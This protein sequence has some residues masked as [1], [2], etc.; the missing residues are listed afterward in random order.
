M[1]W[2]ADLSP[3]NGGSKKGGPLYGQFSPRG[4]NVDRIKL[5]TFRGFHW[6]S[7]LSDSITEWGRAH[8]VAPPIR[9]PAACQLGCQHRSVIFTMRPSATKTE[10]SSRSRQA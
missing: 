7:G 1:W 10:T 9:I 3:A 2:G 6:L 5:L 4:D 8:T